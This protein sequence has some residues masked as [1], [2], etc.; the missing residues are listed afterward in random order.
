[1]GY[2]KQVPGYGGSTKRYAVKAVADRITKD[3]DERSK[4]EAEE[5]KALKQK[6]LRGICDED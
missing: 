4:Q 1:L 5:R 6:R 3:Q 2:I